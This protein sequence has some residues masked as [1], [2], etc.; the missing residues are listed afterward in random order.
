MEVLIH[1]CADDP[2]AQELALLR[3]KLLLGEDFEVSAD[4][5]AVVLEGRGV[6]AATTHT[7]S[8][9]LLSVLTERGVRVV[10]DRD[11]VTGESAAGDL[12]DGV[13]TASASPLVRE[14]QDGDSP[15]EYLQQA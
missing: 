15:T 5:I 6:T 7:P 14:A 1:V 12:A 8:P 4:E 9:G 11:S 13:E 10:V 3:A 2:D